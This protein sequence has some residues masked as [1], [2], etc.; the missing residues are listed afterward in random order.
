MDMSFR[1]SFWHSFTLRAWFSL[2]TSA[3]PHRCLLCVRDFARDDLLDVHMTMHMKA[4]PFRCSH[5]VSAAGNQ[6][7]GFSCGLFLSNATS[8]HRPHPF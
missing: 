2:P 1:G 6:C 8:N 4:K 5:D 3:L 7:A